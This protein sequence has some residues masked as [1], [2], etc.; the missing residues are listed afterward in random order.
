[1]SA[2]MPALPPDLASYRMR[3]FRAD[4][5]A[6]LT[7]LPMA[8]PQAMAYAII[9]GA[10]PEHGIYACMLPVVVAAFLGSS[11][12][13]S[14][15]PTNATSLVLFSGMASVTL[16]GAAL[17]S[18]PPDL[19]MPMI[20]GITLF[21]GILQILMGLAKLGA[22]VHFISLSVMTAFSAGM[23]LL[24]FAGQLP[25]ALGA[26]DISGGF[27]LQIAGSAAHLARLDVNPWCMLMAGMPIVLIPA[28]GRISRLFPATPAALLVTGAVGHILDVAERG[29]PMAGR[30]TDVMPPFS[31]PPAPDFA[32]MADL[33]S[34]ALALAVIGAVQSLAI[35]KQLAGIRND[36]FDGNRELVAQGLGN[37]AASLT[38][39][40]PGA[41]SFTRS[42][43]MVAFGA[44]TRMASILAGL[45][46]LPLLLLL[47]PL[48]EHLPLPALSGVLLLI[49]A[50][51]V[52]P[53]DIR[54]CLVSTKVDAA[55][56]TCTFLASLALP[57]ARAILLG[58]MVSFALFIYKAAH[59]RVRRLTADDALLQ[60]MPPDMPDGFRAYAVEGTL[61]FGA[62]H[63]LESH[64]HVGRPAPRLVLLHL[65]RVFWLDASGARAL[66][67]FL[68]R[69]IA[70]GTAA[71]LVLD[72]PSVRAI[73]ERTGL[74]DILGP[75]FVAASMEEGLKLSKDMLLRMPPQDATVAGKEEPRP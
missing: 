4:L 45:L 65:S 55:V 8:A 28:L 42:A 33:F 51:S 53:G 22:L 13:L 26:D 49:A 9:A 60:H 12:F 35:G 5:L 17:T 18:L 69:R 71:V 3:D 29:V 24:I 64:L 16:G 67:H 63:E 70:K 14:S 61:F 23:A 30:I 40:I 10:P 47:A 32:L 2:R 1:M 41:G 7:L 37:V 43:P 31:L 54:F 66:E 46:A 11:R 75:G 15:G 36:P 19:R 72:T 44:R 57:L 20:F 39:G 56:F 38:S 21:C 34:P 73:L 52:R 58:V 48:L 50:Q 59:P 6:A 68:E 74:F 25:T 62:I 27:F